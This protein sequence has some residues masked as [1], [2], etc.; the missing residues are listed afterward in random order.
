MRT[1][2]DLRDAIDIL[3]GPLH[4]PATLLERL[5]TKPADQRRPTPARVLKPLI[6]ALVVVAVVVTGVWAFGG[7]RHNS[8][9]NVGGTNPTPLL[10]RFSVSHVS[11]YTITRDYIFRPS[12]PAT[13]VSESASVTATGGGKTS[14]TI[15]FDT[16]PGKLVQTADSTTVAG[17]RY[18]FRSGHHVARQGGLTPAQYADPWKAA[19]QDAYGPQ[20]SWHY[21][22]GSQF[23]VSGTFGFKPKTYTYDNAA[24]RTILMK[25]AA[26]LRPRR[27]DSVAMPFHLRGL[28]HGLIPVALH[29]TPAEKVNT[30]GTLNNPLPLSACLNYATP[31]EPTPQNPTESIL[32]VCRAKVRTTQREAL[33]SLAFT[34]GFIEKFIV[35]SLPDGTFLA[36]GIGIG[37]SKTVSQSDLQSI[38]KHADV[39][40]RLSD[41]ATWLDVN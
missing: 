10:W 17:V 32:T 37:H 18:Y 24:A 25:L 19:G 22:D 14:G 4:D 6:A 21:P 26:A 3:A 35:R 5:V 38:A 15:E 40:P 41:T 12:V 39:T 29:N 7:N 30:A 20:L 31:Q 9:S 27:L 36:V 8:T 13:D 28:G 34:P 2:H 33:A 11:G 16:V 23:I 1:E